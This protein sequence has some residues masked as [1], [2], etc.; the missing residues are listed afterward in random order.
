MNNEMIES[1]M[2]RKINIISVVFY[3][4]SASSKIN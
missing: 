3:L 4:S 1:N 2:K